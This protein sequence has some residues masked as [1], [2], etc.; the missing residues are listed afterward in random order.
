MTILKLTLALKD[1]QAPIEFKVRRIVNAG[2][3]GRDSESVKAHIAE[4]EKEG[5]APP[6][7]VPMIFPVLSHNI[8]TDNRIEV[9]SPK[10]SGEVEFVLLIQDDDIFVGVGS[11]HTDRDLER[12]SIPC[13]KQ[14]CQNV[15]APTVWRY[16]DIR[17][18]WDDLIMQSWTREAVDGQELLYQKS[19]LSAIMGPE[20]LMEFIR[21]NTLDGDLNGT[22]IYSGTVSALTPEIIYGS[23]FRY[24]LIDE[25]NNNMITG[26]YKVVEL[27]FLKV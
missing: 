21:S 8:T 9:G 7:T 19:Q 15:L 6:P 11:D 2:Y 26:D 17:D 20:A 1:K 22:V 12:Y 23:N 5:V 18:R 10:T 14:I 16:E 27:N 3:T 13:S 4:L 25:L 24:E